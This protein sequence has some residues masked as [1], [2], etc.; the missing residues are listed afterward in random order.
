MLKSPQPRWTEHT[1]PPG[2]ACDSGCTSLHSNIRHWN[3]LSNVT[4]TK[5]IT[6]KI[7]SMNHNTVKYDL[8]SQNSR[9]KHWKTT[10]II[11]PWIFSSSSGVRCERCGYLPQCGSTLADCGLCPISGT[12][13]VCDT[14]HNRLCPY[15]LLPA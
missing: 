14:Q 1:W 2:P 4:F 10:M 6:I 3:P 7:F 12:G 11:C 8:T 9:M 15:C 13:Q 5:L